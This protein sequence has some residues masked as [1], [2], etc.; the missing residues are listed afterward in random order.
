MSPSVLKER[1]NLYLP[2]DLVEDLREHVPARERTSF[3]AAVL[4]R[5]LARLKLAAV[6]DASAGAWRDDDHPELS[7]PA[8][9]ERWI[10]AGRTGL[11]WDRSLGNEEQADG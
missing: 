9:I 5:E 8:E 10:E 1:L 6:I 2:R 3:V 7:S 4:S 11:G